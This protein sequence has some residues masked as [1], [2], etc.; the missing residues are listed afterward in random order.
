MVEYRARR[1]ELPDRILVYRDGVGDGQL[2]YIHEHEL[3]QINAYIASEK[4]RTPGWEPTLAYTVL[5]KRINQRF[6]RTNEVNSRN[7]SLLLKNIQNGDEDNPYPGTIVD[8]KITRRDMFDFLLVSQKVRQGTV[9]PVHYNVIF[10]NTNFDPDKHQ[11]FFQ[12][13]S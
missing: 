1:Q 2:Q 9:T 3:P 6:F 8:S 7:I 11:E 10:D 12:M 4:L 5:K 13:V